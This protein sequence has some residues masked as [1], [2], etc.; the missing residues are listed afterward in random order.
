MLI[1]I[2][3]VMIFLIA[4]KMISITPIPITIISLMPYIRAICRTCTHN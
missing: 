2:A 4:I 3:V 1:A